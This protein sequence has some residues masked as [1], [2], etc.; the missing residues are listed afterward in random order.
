[1]ID[2]GSGTISGRNVSGPQF[3]LTGGKFFG[4]EVPLGAVETDDRGRLLFFG[5]DGHSASK[6]GAP[7]ITFA[8]NDGWHDD[9][10]DGPVRA[11]V[12]WGERTLEAEPAVVAVTPP[13]FGQGLFGT[14]TLYDVVLDLYVRSG[15]VKVPERP[16]FWG[17]IYPI[18]R[19]MAGAQWV[20]YGFYVSSARARRPT[21][22]TRLSW[23]SSPIRRR[24]RGRCAS[25]SS[26]GSA[27]R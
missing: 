5:G 4:K 6:D 2:P 26:P 19:D 12:R 16:S 9:V 23:H 8:N 25:A 11:T 22:P 1:M 18:F 21:R 10:S 15:W 3:H 27:I 24:R 14:V 20:N 13:N 7:A 17:E